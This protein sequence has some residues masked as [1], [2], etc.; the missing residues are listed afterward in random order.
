M[1][2]GAMLSD[3]STW[4]S[5][6]PPPPPPPPSSS[7]KRRAEH[8]CGFM[9]YAQLIGTTIPLGSRPSTAG[10]RKDS[11]PSTASQ[12]QFENTAA[13]TSPS[14]TDS[15]GESSPEMMRVWSAVAA[16]MEPG[17]RSLWS[18]AR[19]VDEDFHAT[20]WRPKSSKEGSKLF[21]MSHG[22][23]PPRHHLAGGQSGQAVGFSI[24]ATHL[25][26]M[27]NSNQLTLRLATASS[28]GRLLVAQDSSGG[29]GPSPPPHEQRRV[30]QQ[31]I[32]VPSGR[33]STSSASTR[34]AAPTQPGLPRPATSASLVRVSVTG[35]ASAPVLPTATGHAT[36]ERREAP[37]TALRRSEAAAW[38]AAAPTPTASAPP[39]PKPSPAPMQP[40]HVPVAAPH[41]PV[42]RRKHAA[43]A[44]VED[45][46]SPSKDA[47]MEIISSSSSGGRRLEGYDTGALRGYDVL[48]GVLGT[49]LATAPRVV[50]STP[51]CTVCSA[52]E[53][54]HRGAAVE[55]TPDT[56]PVTAA[57]TGN[58][59]DEEVGDR[60]GAR[61]DDDR[62]G[63]RHDDDRHGAR[64]DDDRYG[65]R[66]DDD[67]YGAGHAA[68]PIRPVSISIH[69]DPSRSISIRPP[70]E[71]GPSLQPPVRPPP[72]Q[73]PSDGASASAGQISRSEISRSASS[74]PETAPIVHFVSSAVSDSAVSGSAAPFLTACDSGAV[75]SITCPVRSAVSSVTCPV[76]SAVSSTPSKPPLAHGTAPATAPAPAPAPTTATPEAPALAAEKSRYPPPG[77]RGMTIGEPEDT[78]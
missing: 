52:D 32:S 4:H 76:R 5:V 16:T 39:P 28:T 6:P 60:H 40:A 42:P 46:A 7:L 10:S 27:L 70:V 14:N 50:S 8:F 3:E 20:R 17:A 75:S 48:E 61:H 25:D 55:G 38:Q 64:H 63:A 49:T 41:V 34:E 59:S 1:R 18:P 62:H 68:G 13:A 36:D 24:P 43:L 26:P 22:S 73:V 9:E 37:A 72:V 29:F 69:L 31:R 35:S 53:V 66:H 11:R 58:Y 45:E 56:A 2:N 78:L 21:R 33:P 57:R 74:S 19:V 67:R 12:R 54:T 77:E 23:L 65:A 71:P 47:S 44:R 30:P 51:S 15:R